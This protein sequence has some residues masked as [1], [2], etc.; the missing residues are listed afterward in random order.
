MARN[1]K[2]RGPRYGRYLAGLFWLVVLAAGALPHAAVAHDAR[3][4]S[5]VIE[6]TAP[7]VY[8]IRLRIPPTVER[9]NLPV[10]AL[11][12]GCTLSGDA[13]GTALVRAGRESLARCSAG[14][15]GTALPLRWPLYNPSLTSV[16]QFRPLAHAPRVAVFP[17]DVDVLKLPATPG[18]GTVVLTYM[19]DGIRHIW[20]GIDHLLFVT[21]LLLLA[22]TPRR[23]LLAVSGFTLAH[24]VTLS[25]AALGIVV[26]PIEPT[27]AAIALSVVFLARELLREQRDTLAWRYPG[28]VATS[29]GLL[30]GLGFAAGLREGGL[31]PEHVA[32]ALLSFNLGVEIGQVLFIAAALALVHLGRRWRPA[33][34]PGW[35][36]T[37]T[38]GGY[39][40]GVP[41]TFWLLQRMAWVAA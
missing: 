4:L 30:H 16:L 34:L 3:P 36:S 25:L 28:L 40:I 12:A 38:L 10:M 41:A 13:T 17:P 19:A 20:S 27:E 9:D 32:A 5:V 21:G 6:E 35:A 8:A 11:P 1:T 22:R 7:Q 23:I 37:A 14:L 2:R 24:S 31:P 33:T 39:A 18:P 29:F 15:D 26:P